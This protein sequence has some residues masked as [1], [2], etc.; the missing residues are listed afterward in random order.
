MTQGK[1]YL[2]APVD[3]AKMADDNGLN[4]YLSQAATLLGDKV[5]RQR[6][7]DCISGRTTGVFAF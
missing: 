3:G 5:L 2:L 7:I 6:K 1:T 4:T